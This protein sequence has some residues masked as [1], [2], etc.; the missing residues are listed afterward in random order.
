MDGFCWK[1]KAFWIYLQFIHNYQVV[2]H[3][4]PKYTARCKW[5]FKIRKNGDE[6]SFVLFYS[7]ISVTHRRNLSTKFWRCKT[8]ADNYN[9]RST[10]S[11]K[12]HQGDS[13]M[14]MPF[15]D[16]K[17]TEKLKKIPVNNIRKEKKYFIPLRASKLAPIFI[18]DLYILLEGGAQQY[19]LLTDLEHLVTIPI[20]QSRRD[21]IRRNCFHFC[22]SVQ[23][24]GEN[25]KLNC[26]G[27]Q[28]ELIV[29]PN[30]NK[31]NHRFKITNATWFVG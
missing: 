15:S 25:H 5:I 10:P 9:S 17:R 21:E 12:K 24:L 22:S 20:K 1:Q 30:D 16:I 19:V 26:Y 18:M 11:A 8:S 3:C 13:S 7:G 27:K 28:R 14:S 4:Y 31:K 2:L 29:L 23:T 6:K